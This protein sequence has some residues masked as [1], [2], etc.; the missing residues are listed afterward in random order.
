MQIIKT[1]EWYFLLWERVDVLDM[2]NT[3]LWEATSSTDN[4]LLFRTSL[5]DIE[6]EKEDLK[7][8]DK[9]C[10]TWK[11]E[12]QDWVTYRQ[13]DYLQEYCKK[14][15]IVLPTKEQFIACVQTIEPWYEEWEYTAWCK[16]VFDR[17]WGN[18]SGY[19]YDTTRSNPGEFGALWS[20]SRFNNLNARAL[21][22][23]T[24]KGLI[25]YYH[26][27]YLFPA[28]ALRTPKTA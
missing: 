25:Y 7:V 27:F 20:G 15:R 19:R 22:S 8:E 26:R 13:R 1:T 16:G 23:N 2:T 3:I 6:F 11:V 10:I 28:R 17:I 4:P 21:K 18:L 24:A 14:N 5:W 9:D 12:N